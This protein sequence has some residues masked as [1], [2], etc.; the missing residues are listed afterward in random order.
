MTRPVPHGSSRTDTGRSRVRGS[1][2]VLAALI[3]LL[4]GCGGGGSL[5]SSAPTVPSEYRTYFSV[6]AQRCPG[7]LTPAGLAGQAY[8][9]S[10]FRR[11]AVSGSGAQGLMQIT[12]ANWSRYGTD[13]NGDG[14]ADPFTPADSIATAAKFSCSLAKG[15]RNVPGSRTELRLAAYNAGINAV[16][17]Y[18]AVP[19]YPETE[20][21]VQQVQEWSKQFASAFP[22]NGGSG[23]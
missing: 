16:R 6:A 17:K 15:L 5:V 1:V 14:R 3:L 21:Y 9:E 10:H 22:S 20:N 23:P 18:G 4:A 2:L 7:V 19:P 13:A 11:D 8:V 12:S